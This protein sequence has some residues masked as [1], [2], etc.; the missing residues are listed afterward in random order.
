[1]SLLPDVRLGV[2][3]PQIV[4]LPPNVVDHGAAVEAIELGDAY[5]VC[6]GFPLDD[7]QRFTLRAALGERADGS[8]AAATVGDFE[9]RQSGKNDTVATRELAGLIL[10]GERLIIHTAHEFST[11]NESFLRL[12]G[13]FENWD[14]LRK[15]VSQ[16]RYGNGTQA[17]E[18]LTGQRL[19]YKAR[20]GGSGRGFA[21]ADLVVYDEA[22]HLKVEHVAASGPARLANPNSQAW[23]LGSGG[24]ES[25]VNAWR[26]RRRAL[27]GDGGRFAYV[28]HTAER[29]SL[30]DGRIVSVKP[31]DVL[32]REAWAEANPAYN[33]PG[34]ISDE[35]LSDLFAELGAE[36]FARECL[37]IWEPEPDIDDA[38]VPGDVWA[39]LVDSGSEI[40]SH[41]CYGL[42]VSPNRGW[43]S[44]A[45]AGRRVDGRLHVEAPEH[46][47]GTDWV[48]EYAVGLWE[49]FRLPIRIDKTGPAA[50]FIDLLRN[51]LVEVVEV[52]G[53]EVSQ[54]C[55]QFIDAA[56]SDGLRHLNGASLNSSL[57]GA[58]LKTSGDAASWGRRVSKV[59]ISALCAVTVAVGG[60]PSMVEPLKPMIVVSSYGR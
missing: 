29:V 46:R 49:K 47:P 42:D 19:L 36:L 16:I 15:R 32:D 7:S 43:A 30:V 6:D 25:S 37:C 18:L 51:R 11:A 39:S 38:V 21:K 57:R 23:Y 45:A 59:D 56:L 40:A 10:F 58:V 3:L 50:S 24:L 34:R 33:W 27:E 22:Q 17:I 1:M 55:G 28:E 4:H 60:V 41:R 44:F 53:A 35:S 13:L 8:W 52:S 48:L 2:L 31:A 26:M 54:A 5:G 9:P 14:D 12:V 20:T